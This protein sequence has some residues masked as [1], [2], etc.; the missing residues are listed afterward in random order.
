MTEAT[1]PETGT[2][3]DH[4]REILGDQTY[5]SLARN[6]AT[7]TTAAAA[8]AYDQIDQSRTALNAVAK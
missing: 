1:T 8:Y 6:G 3:V 4:L 2:A 7:M 5:E